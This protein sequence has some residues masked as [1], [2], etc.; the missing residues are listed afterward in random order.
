MTDDGKWKM[1]GGENGR[2]KEKPKNAGFFG[3]KI[4]YVTLSLKEN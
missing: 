3:F 4:V 2:K 1:R